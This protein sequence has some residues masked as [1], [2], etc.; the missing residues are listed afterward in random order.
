MVEDIETIGNFIEVFKPVP[1]GANIGRQGEDIEKGA[2]ILSEGQIVSPGKLGM[3]ASQGMICVKVYEK[4]KVAVISTGSEII[5]V[6]QPISD[7][8]IYDI[9][10]HTISAVIRQSGAEVVKFRIQKD[11]FSQLA[12]TLARAASCDAVVFSGGSS[13]G[14]KDL[15]EEVLSQSGNVLFHGV[16]IKPG[17]PTMFAVVNGKPVFGMPGYPTS[18]LI[19]TY[20]LLGPAIRKAAH[21]APLENPPVSAR[22]SCELTNRSDRMSIVPVYIEGG[23]AIPIFKQSGAISATALASGYLVVAEDTHMVKG[24]IVEVFPLRAS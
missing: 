23:R 18:C 6:D 9:N 10:S 1:T 13:L 17:K 15:L 2:L 20:L 5:D 14:Q 12:N 4:P 19:N 7:G 8:Q 21:L 24:S 22:L 3:L 11:D 16:R